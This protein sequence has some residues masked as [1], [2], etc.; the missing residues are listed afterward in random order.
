M[1]SDELQAFLVSGL[2]MLVGTRD[3]KLTPELT[4]GW[5]P[6]VASDRQSISICI[7]LASGRKTTENLQDNGQIAF[8]F[9][10]PVNYKQ[11]Q[12][13]GSCLEITAPDEDDLA[14]VERHREEFARQ[15]ETVGTPRRFIEA[16]FQHDVSDPP[17][18][19]KIRFTPEQMFDQTPGPGAGARL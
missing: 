13:K 8:S 11:I 6:S 16:L 3:S 1:L 7:S 4:R 15:C 9:A 5:G 10:S 2:G 18:L 19:A 12:V 14:A 17:R